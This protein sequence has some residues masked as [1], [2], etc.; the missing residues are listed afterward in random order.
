MKSEKSKKKDP[1]KDKYTIKVGFFK[2]IHIKCL[3]I[4]NNVKNNKN[5][6]KDVSSGFDILYG[7]VIYGVLGT[8]ALTLFGLDINLLNVFAVGSLLWLIENK[9]VNIITSIL[10][11]I[12]LVNNYN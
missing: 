6:G 11:S 12:K 4:I 9:F 5:L 1:I 10:G 2:K 7:V 3:D 8:L